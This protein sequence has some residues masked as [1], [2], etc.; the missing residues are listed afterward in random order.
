MPPSGKGYFAVVGTYFDSLT[1]HLILF[2]TICSLPNTFF[3]V[4][5]RL[6][7]L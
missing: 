7:T 2:L 3:L 1:A 5:M 6:F 4:A